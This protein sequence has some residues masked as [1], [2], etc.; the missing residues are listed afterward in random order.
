MTRPSGSKHVKD[1]V[2]LLH[3]LERLHDQLAVAVRSKLD[4]MRAADLTSLH[5]GGRKEQELV[6]RIHEREGL[7][8]QIMDAIG[9]HLGMAPRTARLM[10]VSQLVE[11]I[12]PEQGR[13][14]GQAADAL[15]NAVAAVARTNAIAGVVAKELVNHLRRVWAA[16]RPAGGDPVGYTDAGIP[17]LGSSHRIFEAL[18]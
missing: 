17:A 3:Q 12:P 1:L 6:K 10:T 2:K 8:R 7:R 14:V 13:P 4:A 5:A 16:V 18:G 11:R 9:D 15:R